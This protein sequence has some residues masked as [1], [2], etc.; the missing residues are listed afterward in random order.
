MS[1]SEGLERQNMCRSRSGGKMML[2]MKPITLNYV[3][4]FKCWQIYL[5]QV[6]M[7]GTNAASSAYK[8]V[9]HQ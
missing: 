5:K 8:K 4:L 9:R 6:S 7:C 3:L 2:H 1:M